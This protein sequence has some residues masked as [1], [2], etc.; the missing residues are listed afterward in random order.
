M[1]NRCDLEQSVF[2][3]KQRYEKYPW[4]NCANNNFFKCKKVYNEGMHEIAK[5]LLRIN[6]IELDKVILKRKLSFW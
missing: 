5:E 4:A 6:E 2:E 3:E 1:S